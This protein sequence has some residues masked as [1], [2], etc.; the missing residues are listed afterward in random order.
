[1]SSRRLFR[2]KDVNVVLDALTIR[3]IYE[4]FIEGTPRSASRFV[5]DALDREVERDPKGL[6]VHDR[7]ALRSIGVTGL[8]PEEC[9]ASLHWYRD[10]RRYR[11]TLVWF[12]GVDA[13]PLATLAAIL[14][15]MEL[16]GLG[17][18]EAEVE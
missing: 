6:F 17:V 5:L 1:M 15:A 12:E 9:R 14:S 10:G 8:P 16:R 13:D 18:E 2:A 7:E 3:A 11:M 4:G